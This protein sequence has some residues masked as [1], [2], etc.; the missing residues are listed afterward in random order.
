MDDTR[1]NELRAA[2]V[3][4]RI[5]ESV[6]KAL[7]IVA[8]TPAV[9]SELNAKIPKESLPMNNSKWEKPE[10]KGLTLLG[11]WRDCEAMMTAQERGSFVVEEAD[12]CRQVEC[13][14][15]RIEEFLAANF[16]EQD[17]HGVMEGKERTRE[18][19]VSVV[20]EHTTPRAYF[21]VRLFSPK[22]PARI[23][24]ALTANS[25]WAEKLQGRGLRVM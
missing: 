19:S 10:F 3:K 21:Q 16:M 24:M 1:L 2:L 9:S 20:R 12:L 5:A 22:S 15:E 17:I 18:S 7:L 6:A 13:P 14:P 25:E 11:P 8:R 23:S 4:A